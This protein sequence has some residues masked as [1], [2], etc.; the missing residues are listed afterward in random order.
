MV[1]IFKFL[2]SLSACDSTHLDPGSLNFKYISV[3]CDMSLYIR[4]LLGEAEPI[5]KNIMLAK[6]I[7]G[8]AE[9]G[10][11]YHSRKHDAFDVGRG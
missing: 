6:S 7:V 8:D 5:R 9:G 2:Y 11:H 3:V 10:A 1:L 4:H